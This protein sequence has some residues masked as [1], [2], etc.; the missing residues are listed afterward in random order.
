MQTVVIGDQG[1]EWTDNPRDLMSFEVDKI[2]AISFLE[3]VKLHRQW[4]NS[5]LTA[6][7]RAVKAL[8][9]IH[10]GMNKVAP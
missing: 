6:A 4:T 9:L 8:N 5:T 1:T 10:Q 7:T 3:G 2:K